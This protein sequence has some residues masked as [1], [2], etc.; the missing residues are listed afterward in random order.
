MGHPR[1]TEGWADGRAS[2]LQL[3]LTTWLH[4]CSICQLFRVAEESS[5]SKLYSGL[6][7]SISLFPKDPI[8]WPGRGDW[9]QVLL[10]PAAEG[11][12][13]WQPQG[14]MLF[15]SL[16][17]CIRIAVL[18]S[19]H[20]TI[21]F[22]HDSSVSSLEWITNLQSNKDCKFISVMAQIRKRSVYLVNL[23]R[24]KHYQ[25]GRMISIAHTGRSLSRGLGNK[26][27]T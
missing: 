21:F 18:I 24:R 1:A 10:S 12:W 3:S 25:C 26:I 8:Y 5:S 15:R 9:S 27:D 23:T 22:F 16:G 14:P 13:G 7:L 4:D 20:F 11:V 19:V 6:L 2:R 17:I